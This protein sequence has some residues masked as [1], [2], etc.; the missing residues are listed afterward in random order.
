MKL[1][2]KSGQPVAET[3]ERRE[4]AEGNTGEP[5]MRRTQSRKNV[6]RGLI[7]YEKQRS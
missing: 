5:H 6:S 3:V 1:A 2:N 7:V 4:R